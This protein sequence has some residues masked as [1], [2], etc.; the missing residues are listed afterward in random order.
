MPIPKKDGKVRMCV[1]FR[2]LNKGFPK[3]DFLLPHIDVL[4]DN[5]TG[6]A[7]MSFMDGFLRYNQIKMAPRDMT[8][9]TFTTEWGNYCY[10]V[11]PFGLKNASVTYQRMA[12]T[13]LHDM[14]HNEVEVYVDDM[15]MKSKEREGQIIN[16]RKFFER[17]KEYRMGLNPQKCTFGV[18]IGKLLGFLVND[19]GIEV[20]PSN[21]K[22][23]LEIPPPKSEKEIRGLLGR[24]QYISRF[25]A[26]L[27][28]TCEPIFKLL[29]KNEPHEWNEECQKYFELNKEYLLHPPILIPPMHGKPLLLYLSIIEDAVGSML[30]QEDNDKNERAI[31]YLSKRFHDYEKPIEKSCFALV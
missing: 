8:K 23:I 10:T 15:I 25:I 14:M 24:L 6:S 19:R 3:D 22:P 7:L 30:A 1:N 4:V 29:R 20:D 11:I 18:T 26:K 31:Y 27:T 28:S 12:K 9:T 21:I 16:L 17:V 5:T 13:L 2:D